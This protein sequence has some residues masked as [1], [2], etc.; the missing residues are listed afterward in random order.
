[1]TAIVLHPQW[2]LPLVVVLPLAGAAVTG[3]LARI[4]AAAASVIALVTAG[5]TLAGVIILTPAV[6]AA[7]KLGWS[8]PVLAERVEFAADAFSM[9]FALIGAFVWLCATIYATAYLRADPA[10]LR[11]QVTSLVVLA[12]NLGV[13]LAGDLLTLFVC[14][15]L[16]GLVALL[17]VIHD[18]S[19]TA[20]QAGIKYFWM[21]LIGGFALLAGIFLVHVMAGTGTIAPLPEDAGS[22]GMVVA[23]FSLMLVGFGVK[24]GMVP[25]HTWLPDAHPAAPAPASALLSGVMIK[26]GAYGIFRML[27]TLFQADSGLQLTFQPGLIVLWLGIATM[28]IGVTLALGQHHAKR[29]LAWHSVS[30]MGFVLTGLG[31]GAWLGTEGA[32]GT[33]GGLLHMVNHA[34]FKSGL[35]LGMGAVALYAGTAD[36]YRLGGLWRKMPVTFGCMLIAA[37]GITGVPLFNGFVSKCMIHHALV[38][39]A[40]KD[41]G[42]WLVLAE[43]IYLVTCAGTVAS[44]VKLIGLVFIRQPLRAPEQPVRDAAPAMGIAMLL[45]SIPVIVLGLRPQVMLN[46]LMVPGMEALAIPAEPITRYLEVYF[47]S[48]TDLVSFAGMMAGGVAVFVIGFHF[49]LFKLAAPAWVGVDYWYRQTATGFVSTCQIAAASAARLRDRISQT[50]WNSLLWLDDVPRKSLKT[51]VR[52]LRTIQKLLARTGRMLDLPARLLTVT[53]FRLAGSRGSHTFLNIRYRELDRLRDQFITEA[54]R[55]AEKRLRRADRQR[56]IETER[57]LN[58]TR[59][60]AGLIASRL[61]DQAMA[62]EIRQSGVTPVREQVSELEKRRQPLVEETVDLTEAWIAGEELEQTLAGSRFAE[63]FRQSPDQPRPE[64]YDWWGELREFLFHPARRHWPAT[65]YPD[66]GMLLSV[67]RAVFDRG[68]RDPGSGLILAF[69]VLLGL[70]VAVFWM[71]GTAM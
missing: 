36:M 44:F 39:G 51:R 55:E 67:I 68:T 42:E 22:P 43:W 28:L 49:D 58:F 6:L 17:L 56:S 40:A 23:A 47:F 65:E 11:F 25:L 19:D 1:M 59:Q 33:A 61:L 54:G 60:V 24:A 46:G 31:A 34:L 2:L 32:M 63:S 70:I 18:G 21:T 66:Q 14:F 50:A 15:E 27:N 30:Q 29:M 16:L 62:S 69:T 45:L 3:G 52:L 71:T 9:V 10:R 26:A 4:H 7:G 35:F 41:G 64:Q 20:R 12:A 57:R 13:V 48:R 8:F 5:L 53:G 37:A 38:D